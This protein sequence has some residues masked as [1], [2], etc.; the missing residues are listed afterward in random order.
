[1]A[2]TYPPVQ[3]TL[4]GDVLTISRFLNN[5]TLIARRLRTLAEQRFIAD[6]LLTGR[7]TTDSGSVLYETSEGIYSDRAPKSVQPGAEYPL[8]PIS[9]GAPS[10]AKTVKWGQDAEITDESIS[11]QT[12]EPG[13][14]GVRQAGQSAGEDHRRRRDGGDRVGG[15]ADHGGDRHVDGRARRTSCATSRRRRR[16]SWR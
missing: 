8:T 16:T 13:R 11:R 12:D 1:M 14:E 2:V 15:H 4:S 6:V 9:T 5:P 7:F 10:L 3:P